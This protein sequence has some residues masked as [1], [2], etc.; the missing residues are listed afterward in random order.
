[1]K[2][3]GPGSVFGC[4]R[5]VSKS[6]AC[7]P[8]VVWKCI[9]S[10]GRIVKVKRSSLTRKNG[11]TRSCGCLRREAVSKQ[12]MRPFS[13]GQKFGRLTV[14]S[15][16]PVK[17][18]RS[19]FW[20]CCCECGNELMVNS[21]SLRSGNTKSCGCRIRNLN[22]ITLKPTEIAYFAGLYDG[23]G[24]VR[25]NVVHS[26][27][28]SNPKRCCIHH[29]LQISVTNNC[30]TPLEIFKKAFGGS[31]YNKT[32]R[33]KAWRACGVKALEALRSMLPYL[34]IK[35]A[36]VRW[37]IR[38]AEGI[39]RHGKRPVTKQ[40][41]YRRE[42]IRVRISK[43]LRRYNDHAVLVKSYSFNDTL[44]VKDA[45]RTSV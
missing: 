34:V 33:S 13:I 28:K 23:E 29:S 1:M 10:C 22:G 38:F 8:G 18:K 26:K 24:S 44:K 15:S 25:I 7:G 40:E 37:A 16:H 35:E 12:M 19:L 30:R 21:G 4:L 41:F 20:I 9:C 6:S 14:I 27:Y 11:A 45:L 17:K 43:L 3:V 5:I 39:R 31:I 42:R 36:P 32:D 2:I